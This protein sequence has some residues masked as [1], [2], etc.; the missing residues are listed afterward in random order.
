MFNGKTL[1]YVVF[2][3]VVVGVCSFVGNQFK[4]YF[5]DMD[6][7]DDYQLVKKY[8]LDESALYGDNRPK[9][10]VHT[11]YET[12]SRKW[13]NF[14]SRNT[15]DL[16][17]PYL[18]ITVQSM[19]NHCG[20]DFHVCLID[21]E[22]F[23]RLIPTWTIDLS[24]TPEPMRSYYRDIAMLQL[25][26]RYGG[27]VVPNSFLCTRS[28]KPLYEEA[29]SYKVPFVFEKRKQ[30]SFTG[31]KPFVPN[32][33]MIGA[34]K[35]DP[36]I[37]E[38][39]AFMTSQHT[40]GHFSAQTAFLGTIEEWCSTEV[41]THAI[42]LVD[43]NLIGIKTEIGKPILLDDLMSD[44][45]LDIPHDDVLYGILIPSDELLKRPKYQWFSILPYEDAM[46]AKTILSK[47][48]QASMVD[49]VRSFYDQK[50]QTTS[51]ISI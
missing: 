37:Q 14:H 20:D 32:V 25:I 8:M 41:D 18:Y 40:H 3:M 1:P 43:G 28:L 16:N 42:T 51:M 45:F 10:W 48:M 47:Y 50:K 46:Q 38:L 49:S 39:I 13:K 4:Q 9:L 5:T 12:N 7:R 36:K 29:V 6:T 24:T 33:R 21:D 22:T 23:S 31:N 34:V 44:G 27:I 35:E 19:I 30:Q 26:H 17:Q 15:T 11:K 2:G